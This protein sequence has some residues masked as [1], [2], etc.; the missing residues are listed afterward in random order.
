ML[1]FFVLLHVVFIFAIIATAGRRALTGFGRKVVLDLKCLLQYWL[2]FIPCF[3]LQPRNCSIC[4]NGKPGTWRIQS[5][6]FP[7]P[8]CYA[9]SW[10]QYCWSQTVTSEM[11]MDWSCVRNLDKID[12]GIFSKSRLSFKRFEMEDLFIHR[13]NESNDSNVHLYKVSFKR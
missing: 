12:R 3:F 11:N 8:L 2:E 10:C 13:R 1:Y 4:K 9:D 5:T 6:I 7:L